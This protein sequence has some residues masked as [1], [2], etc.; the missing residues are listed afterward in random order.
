MRRRERESNGGPFVP[1]SAASVL[2][3]R[4]MT[5][6][7]LKAAY[8]K[9]VVAAAQP[10]PLHPSLR[11]LPKQGAPLLFRPLA[12][13]AGCCFLLS[14]F[15]CRSS[16][17]GTQ[18]ASATPPIQQQRRRVAAARKSNGL[19]ASGLLIH[20]GLPAAR[21][22]TAASLMRMRSLGCTLL[23]PSRQRGPA[24]L[25]LASSN[26]LTAETAD[27]RDYRLH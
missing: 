24:L 26:N 14:S 11:P 2:R 4:R 8:L 23:A 7:V 27:L 18:A 17:C 25:E 19:A 3:Q 15:R 1:R 9:Q 16:I 6:G 20:G 21:P 10:R 22:H 5:S 12:T 13:T